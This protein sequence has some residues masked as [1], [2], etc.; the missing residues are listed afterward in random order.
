MRSCAG[1][2]EL[3]QAGKTRRFATPH[4]DVLA[5]LDP[6][7]CRKPLPVAGNAEAK[8]AGDAA[9]PQHRLGGKSAGKTERPYP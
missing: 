3:D 1:F 4:D 7:M 8:A 2:P 9:A 5:K 6:G